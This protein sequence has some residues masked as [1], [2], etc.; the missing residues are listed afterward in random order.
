M[1]ED[2]I[3]LAKKTLPLIIED[4]EIHADSFISEEK[5]VVGFDYGNAPS[6]SR[7]N[8]ITAMSKWR[9]ARI[10]YR[11]IIGVQIDAYRMEGGDGQGTGEKDSG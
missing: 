8:V 9:R 5:A 1:W 4:V 10:T 11:L 2:H 7:G 6:F 3:L